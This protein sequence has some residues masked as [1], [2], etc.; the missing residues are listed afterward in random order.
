MV[1]PGGAT[2]LTKDDES[3]MAVFRS[4]PN[5]QCRSEFANEVPQTLTSV[6][7]WSLPRDG[8]RPYRS[9]SR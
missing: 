9:A 4:A 6:P 2:Q 8:H 1:F 3:H 5:R 7:P